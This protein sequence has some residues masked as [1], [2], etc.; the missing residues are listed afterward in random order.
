MLETAVDMLAS[1]LL[2]LLGC[3]HECSTQ[4]V[5]HSALPARAE[6]VCWC[7]TFS[8]HTMLCLCRSLIHDDLPAMVS[9]SWPHSAVC[10][11]SMAVLALCAIVCETAHMPP[12]LPSVYTLCLQDNDD[13]RRGKPTNHKVSHQAQSVPDCCVA[14]GKQNMSQAADVPAHCP[15]CKTGQAANQTSARSNHRSSLC[16]GCGRMQSNASP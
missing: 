3:K 7:N 14:C 2:R 11:E 15:A 1:G 10:P 13:F 8:A 4:S 5:H 12:S 6:A 9:R 16:E